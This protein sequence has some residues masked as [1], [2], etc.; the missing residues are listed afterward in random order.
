MAVVVWL[1]RDSFIIIP[2]LIGVVIYVSAILILHVPSQEDINLLL[3]ISSKF[4][5]RFRK[6]KPAPADLS[7]RD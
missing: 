3:E 5:N 4:I 6:V 7:V 1:F 2:I